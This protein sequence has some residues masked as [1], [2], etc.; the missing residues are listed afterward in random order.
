MGNFFGLTGGVFFG[1]F[2][3]D[4]L[5]K[6]NVE[7]LLPDAILL[8]APV[9][10]PM[11]GI[12][13]TLFCLG[14]E[15]PKYMAEPLSRLVKSTRDPWTD[16]GAEP[17]FEC[18]S[19]VKI[20]RFLAFVLFQNSEPIRPY[21]CMN[22]NPMDCFVDD[23]HSLYLHFDANWLMMNSLMLIQVDV[24]RYCCCL[25]VNPVLVMVDMMMIELWTIVILRLHLIFYEIFLAGYRCYKDLGVHG[26]FAYFF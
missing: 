6:D 19:K 21:L 5:F 18:V 7:L 1:D 16:D 22:V 9:L 25:N 4:R 23:L 3:F 8:I 15:H 12:P 24:T 2:D 13:I 14:G 17:S 20:M 11:D 10:G 26:C